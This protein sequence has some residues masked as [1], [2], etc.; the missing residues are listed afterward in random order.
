MVPDY[1]T[2]SPIFLINFIYLFRGFFSNLFII[3]LICSLSLFSFYMLKIE[4]NVFTLG[5]YDHT[6][7]MWD[8]RSSSVAM[9]MKHGAP[10][11]CVIFHQNGSLCISSGII[12]FLIFTKKK[13]I[14]KTIFIRF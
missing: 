6:I 4:L 13:L 10:V 2:F 5:S 11:E 9:E 1:I 14:L 7:K 8:L 3:F 12:F